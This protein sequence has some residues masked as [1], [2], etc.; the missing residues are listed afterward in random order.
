MSLKLAGVWDIECARWDRFVVGRWLDTDGRSETH[1]SEEAFA[2][3]MLAKEGRW[4]AHVGGKYDALWLLDHACR[5]GMI[6]SAR[7]RGSMV[8]SV[9]IGKLELI[10]SFALIPMKLEKAAALGGAVK[11]ATGLKCECGKKNCKGFCVLERPLSLA[12][13]SQV[14]DYLEGDCYSLLRALDALG[15]RAHDAQIDLRLTI[16]STAWATAKAWLDLP[17]SNHTLGRYK[18]L[19]EGY[20]GGRTEV[21]RTRAESGHSYDI[22]SSY[23]AAL[24]VVALPEGEGKTRDAVHAAH[25][26]ESGLEGIFCADVRVDRHTDIPPLPHRVEERLLYPVGP[27]DS[28]TWTGLTLRHAL[29]HGA[30]IERMHWAYTYASARPVL[31]PYAERVWRMRADA[32]AKS[33]EIKTRGGDPLSAET[34]KQWAAWYKWL[35]NSLTGKLAMRPEHGSLDF[36]PADERCPELEDDLNIIAVTGH[37][38]YVEHEHV[39]VDPCAHVQWAGYLTSYA[40]RELHLQLLH[41]RLPIYCDTDGA[42]AVHPMTRRLGDELGEWGYE[43]PFTKWKALAPKLYSYLD[44][45]G[46]RI[47]K[48]KGMSGLDGEGFDGLAAGEAWAI[49]TGVEGMRTRLQQT[50][51]RRPSAR[52]ETASLFKR[53][54]LSRSHKPI[55]G[56]CGGRELD[57]GGTVTRPTTIARFTS[58]FE[59]GRAA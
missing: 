21:F 14:E 11:K 47:V 43:G 32:A 59:K 58:R 44:K 25:D 23:P 2:D 39:R 9:K 1:W 24:A 34:E 46:D 40:S 45:S 41:A 7:L 10:D 19:R 27:I 30:K 3:A 31:A 37:G 26:F 50:D 22:H 5:R 15:K 6:W 4:Y 54:E 55:R 38:A 36:V 57:V 17:K 16:G 8:L 52:N 42:K 49:D 33:E 20:Y 12:E 35:A 29:E 56:W 48:G 53:R 13:R 51:V 28:G 18:T